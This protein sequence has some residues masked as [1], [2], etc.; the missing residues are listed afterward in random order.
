[1]KIE[2]NQEQKIFHLST[3]KMSYVLNVMKNNQLGHLYYGSPLYDAT[4][5]NLYYEKNI[6]TVCVYEK[7]QPFTLATIRQENPTYGTTDFSAGMFQIQQ[8]NGSIITNFEYEK[9]EIITDHK[10]SKLPHVR[11]DGGQTLVIS[12]V[13]KEIATTIKL[14]YTIFEDSSIVVR[15][16]EFINNGTQ[17][18]KITR[19]LSFSIDF[20]MD[21]F[22]MHQLDGAWARERHI[23]HRKLVPGIQA[24]ESQLGASS[25]IQNPFLYLTKDQANETA[26]QVYGFALMYSGS[27]LGQVEVGSHSRTR[28]S[29]G[30]HP[31]NFGWVLKP[32]SNFQTPQALLCYSDA[33]INSMSHQY[34]NIIR[35]NIMNPITANKRT[36]FLTN[37]WEATYFDFNEQTIF[38]LANKAKEVGIE[39]FVLDDGWFK[40]RN[41]D[42]SSLGDWVADEIKLPNGIEGLAN[43]ITSE[44]D[45]E[46]GLWFEP[47]MISLRSDLYEEHPEFAIS[48]PNRAMSYGRQQFVLDFANPQVIDYLFEKMSAIINAAPIT[49]IKWDMNR[50][51][52]EPYSLTLDINAQ[53]EFM[54]RYIL[55]V[56]EL[57]GRLTNQFPHILFE[58]CAGGGG[59]FDLGLLPFAPQ[60]WTSDN[61]D[62]IQRLKTQYGTSVLYPLKS[63]GAHVTA[64]NN[65][66]TSRKSSLKFKG[67]VALFGNF[68]YELDFQQLTDE[69]LSVCQQQMAFYDKYWSVIHDGDFF[70]LQ[71]PFE[72]N[73]NHVAWMAKNDEH[74][75]VGIYHILYTANSAVRYVKL[76]GLDPKQMYC[77]EQGIKYSGDQLMTMGLRIENNICGVEFAEDNEVGTR[78]FSST[79]VHLQTVN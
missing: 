2:F 75:L 54:H 67:D 65:H 10:L 22:T 48:T 47:E 58:S 62:P 61:T 36:P 31:N 4:L 26:G 73:E 29:M 66:Q 49:Y 59:R 5:S 28:V 20:D 77:D 24:I 68:G 8:E 71:S 34:H 17:D 13:D 23:N 9:F 21:N 14:Y 70:R 53:G 45:I 46:F 3:S 64:L 40:K 18:L 7:D 78:D 44:L 39:L 52:T 56:Y 1:M 15:S 50:N 41:S 55:G 16:S 42:T 69:Q 63:M 33:G 79:V 74:I 6:P 11:A 38:Q 30:I 43:K 35:S 60:A 25:H 32:N 37:N 51:I 72:D 12:L 19:A 76:A 57:F 27:F